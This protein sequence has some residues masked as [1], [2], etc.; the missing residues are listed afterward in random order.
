MPSGSHNTHRYAS[1]KED[2]GNLNSYE[3]RFGGRTIDRSAREME[4]S[5]V[6]PPVARLNGR[7]NHSTRNDE[8]NFGQA[9]LQPDHNPIGH[10]STPRH[11]E[12]QS[13]SLYR[14]KVSAAT[15]RPIARAAHPIR[16]RLRSVRSCAS[17]DLS[18]CHAPSRFRRSGRFRITREAT[19]K[20][21]PHNTA[22]SPLI[23]PAQTFMSAPS[24]LCHQLERPFDA[25]CKT[26]GIQTHPST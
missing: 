15:A 17:G 6:R 23:V 20:T 12:P 26:T 7:P 22:Q 5:R 25:S 9:P 21:I 8:Q 4:A 24:V 10:P 1:R 14:G 16:S 18:A 3:G 19:T 11:S 2:S 13:S